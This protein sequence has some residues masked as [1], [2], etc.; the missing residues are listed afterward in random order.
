VSAR[1]K[2][3]FRVWVGQ[4]RWGRRT[5]YAKTI[6]TTRAECLRLIDEGPFYNTE[7]VRARLVLDP[8]PRRKAKGRKP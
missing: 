8:P 7:P 1:K 6:A 2:R 5:V 4:Y 3:E